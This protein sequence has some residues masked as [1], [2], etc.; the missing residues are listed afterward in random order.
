MDDDEQKGYTWETG[1]AEGLNIGEVLVEDEGGSIEKSIARYVADSKK[2]LRGVAKPTKIRLGI[3]RH[4]MIVIDCSRFMTNKAMPPS[5]FAATLKVLL[6][7]LEKFFEQNP[8]AQIGFI[9]CKDK[10]AERLAALTGN[11]RNLKDSLGTLNEMF[12]GGDFS[13]QNSLQLACSN[14]R[15]LP[16]HVSRE[17]I[18]IMGSLTTIDPGNIFTTIEVLKSLNIRSSVIGLAA[19]MFVCKQLA[20]MTKGDFSV[21]LDGD[22]MFTLFAKHTV[23]PTTI[24]SAECNAIRVGFPPHQKITAR[25]FCICHSESGPLSDR[26]FICEQCGVRHCSLPSECPVCRLTLVAAPQLARAFRHLLP[27]TPF[28]HVAVS[29]EECAACEQFLE[30]EAYQCLKCTSFFCFDCDLLLHESLHVCPMCS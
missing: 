15:D 13:L 22:H 21:A 4:V 18:V 1:Y 6:A 28:Q 11:I 14:L 27:L 26:G 29:N 30:S 5:R 9:T 10:K 2:K 17:I 7:F 12:C 8:I 25:S 23:P 16:G 19:E 24:R 3:M 20:Q